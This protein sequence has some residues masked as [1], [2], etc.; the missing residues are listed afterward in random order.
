VQQ[1]I[2][3]VCGMLVDAAQP[4]GG[5]FADGAEVVH[6]CNPRCREKYAAAP[7][8]Y[9]ESVDPVCG[10]TVHRTRSFPKR[11]AGKPLFFCSA[12]C[13]DRQPAELAPAAPLPSGVREEV[14]LD[15]EGMTCA[16]CALT[17]EKALGGVTGVR[18]ATV[19]FAAETAHVKGRVELQS[20]VSAVH[21]AGYAARVHESE[22]RDARRDDEARHQRRLA[23]FA[24]ALSLPV[25]A[26]AMIPG[27]HFPW[28]EA[29][30]ATIVVFF[31]GAQFFAIAAR[32]LRHGSA[33][34]DT[35][36]ALGALSAWGYS[37]YLLIEAPVTEHGGHS[38]FETAAMIVTLI[39][40]GRWL[41]ARAK[42]RAG[43]AIRALLDLRPQ[44]ARKIVDGAEVEVDATSL[45]V[46][47]RVRIR[48]GE[49]VPADGVVG[50]GRSSLD[51][52]MLTGESLPVERG[53]GDALTGATVNQHGSL[54]MEVT[55][56]GADTALMQIV[57]L[58][59]A[60][61]GSKAPI[62]RVADRVAGVFVPAV[63]LLAAATLAGWWA[64]GHGS[65]ALLPAI[66]V[67]VIACPC[68]MGLATPTAVMVG[69]GRAAERGILVRD[70]AS[71]ERAHSLDVVVLDKTGTLTAGKPALTDVVTL[72]G[73]SEKEVRHFAASAEKRS[74][75]PVAAAIAAASPLSSGASGFAAEPE[76]FRAFA[77]D[78]VWARVEGREV[79]VGT[80]RW[81]AERGVD[82]SAAQSPA[83]KLEKSARTVALLAVDGKLQALLGVADPIKPHAQEAVARLSALGIETWLVTGDNATTAAAVAREAG[84]DASRVRAGVRPEGKAAVISELQ[85]AGRRV[86]M[87]G[88]GINDGPALA[89]ADVGIALGSGTDV[90]IQAAPLTLLG[91]DLRLVADA[92]SLSRA[93]MRVIRMNLV[94]AFGYNVAAIPL[95]AFGLLQ[96]LGGPMLAAAAMALSSV[97]VVGNSLRLRRFRFL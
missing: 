17:I 24:A 63:L 49:R 47:D 64:T 18:E 34:M 79:L 36:V 91:G 39:L 27:L 94:W 15:L 76:D 32:K 26:L 90:A 46:G 70:A 89:A 11:V 80:A 97:S 61:Q 66:A 50:E 22:R 3:P 38:Y 48:P 35:L 83:Q 51:E 1:A 41:E 84:I 55:R 43:D 65:A 53:P 57:R 2:D 85:R 56:V 30:L 77:G 88:D 82:V 6:F 20:L 23:L 96:A 28:V 16:S 13:R 93:T 75:H 42:G 73:L 62:Q 92:I 4:Q 29:A 60:A 21:E 9:R 78:G 86:G 14:T 67:L 33:N 52:S 58:V 31:C 81:L 12:A 72:G 7:A 37:A 95:A 44:R 10:I 71:L 19:N 45:A 69:T 54:L 8:A 74:E 40:V 25:M 68:A 87:V 59:E 5:S